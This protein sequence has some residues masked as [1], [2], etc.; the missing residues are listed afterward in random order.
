MKQ[1]LIASLKFIFCKIKK[2]LLFI[3]SS[4]L[5][6]SGLLISAGMPLVFRTLPPWLIT[7]STLLFLF[8]FI[9]GLWKRR[10]HLAL[11][12]MEAALAGYFVT[13]TPQEQFKDVE[14]QRIFATKPQINYLDDDRVEVINIRRNRYPDDYDER[15]PYN[16][17]FVTDTFDLSK[18][19]SVQFASVH[20]GGM[21]YVAHTMLNFKFTDGKELAVSVEP[22]TPVGVDREAFTCLCKQQELL[23]ILSDPEDLFDL[24]SRVRGENIYIYEM[25]FTPAESRKLLEF[26]IARCDDVHK[27]PEFYDLIKANC[28]TAMLPGFKAARP[29]LQ[30][31]ARIL[32]NGY[33]DRLLWEQ[34][35]LKCRDGESFESLKSRSFIK[36]KSQGEL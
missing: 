8:L 35:V 9:A 6:L 11:L 13:L 12:I 36:G 33:F 16:D 14:F 29:E 19:D 1:L 21:D 27:K 24:R 2:C 10:Y 23:F 3:L 25:T 15:G 31:D 22:R 28:I 30:W 18:V 5:L 34:D 17:I 4:V 26:I 32:F 20:W 7:L